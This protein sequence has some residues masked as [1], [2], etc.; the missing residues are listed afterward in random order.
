MGFY[1]TPLQDMSQLRQLIDFMASRNIRYPHFDDWLQKTDIQLERGDKQAYLAFSG[2]K[3]I[4]NL[5]F[6]TCRDSGLGHLIEIKNAGTHPELRDR[7]I[8]KFMLR[9]LCKDHER[10]YDGIIGDIRADQTDTL[11]YFINEEEFMPIAKTSLY[12]KSMEEI[13]IF[14]SLGEDSE[15]FIPQVKK[16]IIAKSI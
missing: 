5:V 14:K 11:S 4:S 2:R 7:Y 6:Q 12:E 13:T 9:Q 3:L 10:R 1:F 16:I 15:L 8:M